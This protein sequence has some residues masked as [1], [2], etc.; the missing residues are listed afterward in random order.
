MGNEQSKKPEPDAQPTKPQRTQQKASNPMR[1]T[2]FHEWV[3]QMSRETSVPVSS[4]SGFGMPPKRTGS[5]AAPRTR[6]RAGTRSTD[7][8]FT[9][10]F[11][12]LNEKLEEAYKKLQRVTKKIEEGDRIADD[13]RKEV[14]NL[15]KQPNTKNNTKAKELE[16]KLKALDAD[17]GKLQ[18]ELDE[19]SKEAD[20]S[21]A[22]SK[23]TRGIIGDALMTAGSLFDWSPAPDEKNAGERWYWSE[24]TLNFFM[25]LIPVMVATGSGLQSL[26]DSPE[27]A[28]SA[29][30]IKKLAATALIAGTSLS[31][32]ADKFTPLSLNRIRVLMLIAM[33]L[34]FGLFAIVVSGTSQGLG[35]LV[36]KAGSIGCPT[37]NESFHTTGS[38]VQAID[39]KQYISVLRDQ[40][41]GPDS[42]FV[43]QLMCAATGAVDNF[44]KQSTEQCTSLIEQGVVRALKNNWDSEVAPYIFSILTLK[45]VK[46]LLSEK[47]VTHY[48]AAHGNGFYIDISI[49]GSCK[50]QRV[51]V[52]TDDADKATRFLWFLRYIYSE[53][54]SGALTCSNP[55]SLGNGDPYS[56]AASILRSLFPDGAH[57]KDSAKKI[58]MGTNS[59]D[60]KVAG[61]VSYMRTYPGSNQTLTAE[62]RKTALNL[63]GNI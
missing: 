32:I 51:F 45:N 44:I 17:R 39:I 50:D 61:V 55:Q 47:N 62:D 36:C 48:N 40:L 56:I 63:I 35:F 49:G 3:K 12:T 23:S 9:S 52:I 21:D 46:K 29:E 28:K 16:E 5:P 58:L 22:Q 54:S 11:C 20:K 60:S 19:A 7:Y 34:Y 57:H 1:G 41:M 31:A 14:E 26:D 15:K 33:L 18:R 6:T 10:S 4:S 42:K 38:K 37:I 2:A 59:T 25:M 24:L 13:L 30:T 53:V 27:H 43:F 8:N